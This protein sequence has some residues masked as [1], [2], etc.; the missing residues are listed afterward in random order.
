MHSLIMYSDWFNIFYFAI[1]IGYKSYIYIYIY[2]YIYYWLS[3]SKNID[4]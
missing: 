1:I 4:I 3:L 2:I